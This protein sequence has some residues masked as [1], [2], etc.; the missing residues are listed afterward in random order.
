M[1]RITNLTRR[2][3]FN[4]LQSGFDED[5]G[6]DV[7]H[8]SYVFW[9]ELNPVEF[10]NRLYPLKDLSSKDPRYRNAEEDI[11]VHTIVHPEDYHEGWVFDDDRFSLKD[12]SDEILL[13]FLC[14]IFHPEVR[15]ETGEW[16]QLHRH[17]NDLLSADGY[18]IYCKGQISRRN[19]YG[20][21]DK[22]ACR[23]QSVR[24]Q[25]IKAF[26][27]LLIRQGNVVDFYRKEE[28]DDFTEGVIGVRLCDR[29]G[30]TASKG[31]ALHQF[32]NDCMDEDELLKLFTALI[33][34]YEDSSQCQTD[35]AHYLGLYKKCKSVLDKATKTD[36]L[37]LATVRDLQHEFS[38]EYLNSAMTLMVKM[39]EENPTEAIGKAKELVESC[40]KTILEAND[41]TVDRKWELSK[42]VSETTRL[43]KITPEDISENIPMATTMKK[44]LGNLRAIA[45]S[46][47]ELRN[48]YG[49][50]HGKSA[51][52]K[53]LQ[54]RHARLAVGSS[55]TLVRFLW[56]SFQHRKSQG[57][58][59]G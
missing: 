11:H 42:V 36:K 39:Q 22:T 3:I 24:E 9:G 47:G 51:A 40:C 18:E 29:Y 30:P 10:L 45:E 6:F 48:V 43:L 52:Y 46:L 16:M 55:L 50:G 38:S 17:L 4:A 5:V 31:S 58:L 34:R 37:A 49:S 25:D 33:K 21:R 1:N 7:L 59:N 13:N 57:A 44:L 2:D 23:F 15:Q 19:V 27:K 26:T 54:P 41:V 12:G 8:H 14:E 56:D 20:W 28:F 35:D 53:G 32:V